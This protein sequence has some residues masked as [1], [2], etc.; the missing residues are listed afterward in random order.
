MS[1]GLRR[2]FVICAIVLGAGVIFTVAGVAMGGARNID[3]LADEYS[4]YYGGSTNMAPMHLE[5]GEVFSS[6]DM[7]GA[8]DVEIVEGEGQTYI[9]YDPDTCTPKLAVEGG[10]LKVESNYGHDGGVFNFKSDD[11]PILKIYVPKGTQLENINGKM[12]LGDI[13]V[14][15]IS[16][17]TITLMADLGDIDITGVSANSMTL[18]VDLGDVDINMPYGEDQYT[19][20]ADVS[21][22]ELTI[23]D[24]DHT[25]FDRHYTGGSGAYVIDITVDSG[26]VDIEF[27][28]IGHS[29]DD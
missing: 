8:M 20:T 11:A 7:S 24:R 26:D 18:D 1:K 25:G 22:G 4:W 12:E 29:Y 15:G 16:A 19:L 9:K 28:G 5:K 13:D 21:A 23:N 3:K 2:F 10:V 14:T 6:I 17:N 27:G